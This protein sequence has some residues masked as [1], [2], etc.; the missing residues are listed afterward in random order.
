MTRVSVFEVHRQPAMETSVNLSVN[1]LSYI[2]P[3]SQLAV[4]GQR[5]VSGTKDVGIFSQM[6]LEGRA[7]RC[8][9]GCM[10]A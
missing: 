9:H 1:P 8:V 5:T 4:S 2:Y 3:C 7:E 10:Q 6:A